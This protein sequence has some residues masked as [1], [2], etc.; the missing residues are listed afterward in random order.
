MLSGYNL[1]RTT[2]ILNKVHFG[3]NREIP[4]FYNFHPYTNWVKS[5]DGS[6]RHLFLSISILQEYYK[7]NSSTYFF[8]VSFLFIFDTRTSNSNRCTNR[9]R[10]GEPMRPVPKIDRTE[11][12]TDSARD[13]VKTNWVRRHI[14]IITII[15]RT[16][17]MSSGK[18]NLRRQSETCVQ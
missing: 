15:K 3:T 4:F 1:F 7:Y 6:T 13:A 18:Y 12:G 14:I 5:E 2:R 11:M 8:V 16:E 17:G 9:A 10:P